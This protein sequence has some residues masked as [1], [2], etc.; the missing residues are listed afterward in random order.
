[1][2]LNLKRLGAYFIDIMIISLLVSLISNIT[3]INPKIKDYKKDYNEYVEISK[4]FQEGKIKKDEYQKQV[5]NYSYYLNKDAIITNVLTISFTLIYFVFYQ[6]Y[7]NG[8]T[9]GKRLM[10]IKINDTNNKKISVERYLL[11]SV[12]LYNIV[13]KVLDIIFLLSLSKISYLKTYNILYNVECSITLVIIISMIFSK[14]KRGIH[15]LA[16]GTIVKN[17]NVQNNE[18]IVD[19]KE[20]N[21]KEINNKNIKDVK[22]KDKNNKINKV[23]KEKNL[24]KQKDKKTT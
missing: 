12:I 16:A 24:N 6:W 13:F 19:K 7:K 9:I 3:F 23:K 5:Q 20:V 22:V 18:Q 1:M 14:N 21:N 17:I 15:D 10:Y 4:K 8:Q 11:R 2:N